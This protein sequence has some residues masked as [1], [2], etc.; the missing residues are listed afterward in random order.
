[1]YIPDLE[2]RWFNTKALDVTIRVVKTGDDGQP[3]EAVT[4]EKL[5]VRS[6]TPSQWKIVISRLADL[7][8]YLPAQGL[9]TD[10]ADVLQLG[11]WSA[12]LISGLQDDLFAILALAIGKND[13]FFDLIDLADAVR[14]IGAVIEVNRDYYQK[15]L[16]PLIQHFHPYVPQSNPASNS[17]L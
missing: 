8:Q 2:N 6:F 1:M 14:V 5:T 3:Y 7:M 10:N 16:L 12:V 4:P 15:Q 11:I 9:D 13:E 17:L